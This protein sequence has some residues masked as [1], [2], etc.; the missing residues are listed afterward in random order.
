ME[1]YE[2]K[3]ENIDKIITRIYDHLHQSKFP[4]MS[5]EQ[6]IRDALDWIAGELNEDDFVGEYPDNS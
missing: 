4:G 5:Y 3:Q 2:T 6:G 1:T